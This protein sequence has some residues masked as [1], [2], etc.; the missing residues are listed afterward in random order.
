MPR[1]AHLRSILF[2]PGIVERYLDKVLALDGEDRPDAVLFDLEDS[3]HPDRK[4]DLRAILGPRL[5]PGAGYREELDRRY[6]AVVLRVNRHDTPWFPADLELAAAVRPDI[7]LLPKVEAGAEIDR[8][9]AALGRPRVLAAIETLAGVRNRDEVIGRLAPDDLL[10][11][12]YED[13][14]CDLGIERPDRLD[15][16]GPLSTILMECVRGA[17]E[18]RVVMLDAVSRKFGTPAGL[19]ALARECRFTRRIGL[20]GKFA[21]HPSQVSAINRAFDPGPALAKARDIVARFDRLDD[22]TAVTV[23][24][25]GDM[26]DTPTL[27]LYRRLLERHRGP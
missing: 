23:D 24:E 14:S 13:L 5:R 17:A 22:R 21:I 19:R 20:S 25:R 1:P 12:G 26:I 10:M 4:A 7:V 11:L 3:I 18:A 8:V 27:T 2:V 9:R 15:A 6:R 16:V